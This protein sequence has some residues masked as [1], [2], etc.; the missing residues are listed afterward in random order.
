M[1]TT[2]PSLP[3]MCQYPSSLVFPFVLAFLG[4]FT[5][6]SGCEKASGTPSSE[7]NTDVFPPRAPEQSND[8]GSGRSVG[9][10]RGQGVIAQRTPELLSTVRPAPLAPTPE[11]EPV[12]VL[13][14]PAPLPVGEP[15]VRTPSEALVASYTRTCESAR[16]KAAAAR[17]TNQPPSFDADEQTAFVLYELAL[18]RGCND[19]AA[20]LAPKEWIDLT[21]KQLRTT[22]FFELLVNARTLLLQRNLLSTQASLQGLKALRTL[23]SLSLSGNPLEDA[24]ALMPLSGLS[25]LK[26]LALSDTSLPVDALGTL[27][28]FGALESLHL[29]NVRLS[30]EDVRS[31]GALSRLKVLDVSGSL[32]TRL[33]TSA[34]AAEREPLSL[35]GNLVRLREVDLTSTGAT[36]LDFLTRATRAV[37]IRASGNAITALPEKPQW[38]SLQ[39]LVLAENPL[40]S[41]APLAPAPGRSANRVPALRTL[42]VE[43]TGFDDVVTASR[44]T[45]LSYFNYKK[46]PA[47]AAQ[48]KCPLEDWDACES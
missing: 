36:H 33:P 24:E 12:V 22:S 15:E 3:L 40:S 21:G 7:R 14:S 8:T 42:I 30:E 38:T 20:A 4:A 27:A 6:L 45:S 28:S 29:R 37:E 48:R 31:V 2:R 17:S 16:Q 26:T 5:L 35:L 43:G 11:P 41:L 23:R 9:K 25:W 34:R 18:V 10:G 1:K 44:L 32:V 19:V 13:P 39:A 47:A 46:T